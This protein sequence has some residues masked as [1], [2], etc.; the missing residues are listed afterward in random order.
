[1]KLKSLILGS[2]AAAGLSTAPLAAG[3]ETVLTSL[4]VCDSLGLSGLTISS[5]DNCLQ[6]T[7]GVEYEFIIGDFNGEWA[8]PGVFTIPDDDADGIATHTTDWNSNVDAW[9][10]F[11]GT[12]DSS[13]GPASATIRFEYERFANWDNEHLED[14]GD[15]L[16]IDRAFVSIGDTTVLMAGLKDSVANFDNDEALGWLGL[17]NDGVETVL[18]DGDIATGGDVIQVTS[19]LGN[20]VTIAGGLENLQGTGTAVGVLAYEGNGISANITVLG[21]N[22]F[23]DAA[24]N[25]GIMAGFTGEFDVL[26]VVGAFAADSDNDWDALLSASASLDMFTLAVAGQIGSI[27]TVDNVGFGVNASAEVSTGVTINAGFRWFDPDTAT[28]NDEGWQAAAQL[29]AAV[30]ETVTITG[31]V[32]IYSDAAVAVT[33]VGY[34]SAELAWAPGGGFDS[35]L[36]GEYFSNG[37]YRLTFNASKDFE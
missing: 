23:V 31:E 10:Q 25:W 24:S 8:V 32:G 13:W 4:D 33:S 22:L 19:D 14:S 29:V 15:S 28:A 17:F 1:M 12:A 30:T 36:Q 16:G 6:I 27:A 18:V 3:I 7:G 11:V 9:L 21:D 35:S 26:T 5:A 20:G 34:G 37:A 2:V